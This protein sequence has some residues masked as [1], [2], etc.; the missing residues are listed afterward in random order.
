M[1]GGPVLVIAPHPD[2]EVI[3][4]GGSIAKRVAEGRAVHLIVVIERER[5]FHDEHVSDAEF[6]A[7]TTNAAAT[8]GISDVTQLR[9]PS[10]G[11]ID[12]AT[13]CM[14]LATHFRRI[15]PDIVYLPSLN[16]VDPEHILVGQMGQQMAWMAQEPF[17]PVAGPALAPPPCLVLGYEVWTPMPRFQYVEDITTTMG[18]KLAAMRAYAS[19][20]RNRPYDRGLEGLGAYR[21]VMTGAGEYCEVF[22]VLQLSGSPELASP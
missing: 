21:G 4:C 10:R 16:E 22:E 12:V 15:R 20:L 11:N 1:N 14:L 2:D 3:G 17:F 6:D 5:S 7:E 19:Q 18:V 8:L 13:T 9:C